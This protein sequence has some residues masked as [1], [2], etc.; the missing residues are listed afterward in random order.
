M[1]NSPVEA[2]DSGSN[3][4]FGSKM[5]KPHFASSVFDLSHLVA[6][7]INNCGDVQVIDSF[8]TLPG[9]DIEIKVQS[10][11]RALPQVVPL[12][13]RQRVYTY[14]FYSRLSDLWCNFNTFMTKGYTGDVIKTI[15]VFSDSNTIGMSGLDQPII[16]AGS[17]ADNF[18]LPQGK[19][20][21]ELGPLNC[22]RGMMLLRIFR[23]YFANK[24]Y[25]IN[26]RVLL[27]DDDTRFRLNDNGEL[28]SALDEGV[29]FKF[30]LTSQ[31]YDGYIKP[32][33]PTS[34]P[35]T[36]TQFCH[37]WP[38]DYFTSAL[39]WP[40]RGAETSIFSPSKDFINLQL[41][42]LGD[43]TKFA[44]VVYATGEHQQSSNTFY[45][46]SLLF[47]GAG[48]SGKDLN[49]H[50]DGSSFGN[51][52]FEKSG[53]PLT[54]ITNVVKRN[55]GF[56]ATD[57]NFT[58]NQL[59]E[60]AV[61]QTE[62]EKMARTDGSYYQFGLTF[63]GEKAKNAQDFKPLYIGGCYDSISYTEVL[64]TSAQYDASGDPVGSPLGTYGG[65]GIGS[66]NGY[67]GRVHCDDFGYIMILSCVMPDVYYSQGIER[68]W[69]IQYQS[70]MFLPERAK[71]G[72]RPILKKELYAT[73][74]QEND[75][76]L[77]AWQNPFDEYRYIPNKIKGKLA[78]PTE[79]NFYPYTQSRHFSGET[80]PEYGAVFA[81][82]KD[83]RKDYLNAPSEVAF[84]AQYK[85]DIRAVRP[86]PYKPVPAD[87][88]N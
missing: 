25:Y 58:L 12:Y 54:D 67:L 16:Q 81:E 36:F 59:R 78:D 50:K 21:S 29:D 20:L 85:L 32:D 17:L 64:Q 15:P 73:G 35:Y 53:S 13:S 76:D 46:K 72:L 84:T 69:F 7:T 63:F 9:D 75:E 26:D 34:D 8:M 41:D 88:L 38:D 22:L 62:L 28:L 43:K 61:N 2:F 57:L 1:A 68:D 60:L 40:Q 86:L 51:E 79:L 11:L 6:T 87:I 42:V 31:N 19:K 37:D 30:D 14:A 10:L 18:G 71:L 52:N 66:N 49:F 33:D 82:A 77:W 70:D 45:D 83:V 74:S 65:H 4:N 56:N 24:N 3:Y 27:P 80:T 44:D 39:P 23:D 55:I 5:E 47:E 48:V